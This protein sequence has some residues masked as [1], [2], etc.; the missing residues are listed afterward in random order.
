MFSDIR[1]LFSIVQDDNITKMHASQTKRIGGSQAE[2]RNPALYVCSR[3]GHSFIPPWYYSAKMS[4]FVHNEML[5]IRKV[6]N[7]DSNLIS[8]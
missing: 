5:I 3:L 4:V 2:L 8:K 1:K 7:L 6:S